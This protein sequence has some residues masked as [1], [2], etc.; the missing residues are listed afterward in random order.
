MHTV[1]I[2]ARTEGYRRTTADLDF[3]LAESNSLDQLESSCFVWFRV[4]IVR[5]FEEFLIFGTV[6]QG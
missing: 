3:L 2:V 4:T 6:Q 1:R 5:S